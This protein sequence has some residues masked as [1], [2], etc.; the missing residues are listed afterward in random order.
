MIPS[1]LLIKETIESM[2][3]DGRYKIGDKL[4]SE[5]EMAKFFRVSRD[6]FRSAIKLLE[7]E[8]KLLVKRGVG[9]FVIKPPSN[10][11]SSLDKLQSI[12][13]LINHAGLIEGERQESISQQRCTKEW[14]EK[15]SIE[16]GAP[17][18]VLKRIRTANHE[19]VA[20]SINLLP[21]AIVGDVFDRVPFS[22]SLFRYLLI[23]CGISIIHADTEIVVPHPSDENMK[24]LM[25]T[26]DTTVLML[27]HINYNEEN[28]PVM[29]SQDYLRNDIFNFWIRRIAT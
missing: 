18:Y 7:Q 2:I 10:I 6:T 13:D 3:E 20:F 19:P 23:E 25:H 5:Y 11:P 22:G 16:E 14:A 12:G 21:T 28:Q 8:R 27:K 17:V 29:Y 1:Y 4:P 9:T 24:S 26:R 15:L